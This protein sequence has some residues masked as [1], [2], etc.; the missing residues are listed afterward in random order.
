MFENKNIEITIIVLICIGAVALIAALIWTKIIKKNDWVN[1]NK[2]LFT[3]NLIKK[4][5]GKSFNDK[6]KY[7]LM[8]DIF[9]SDTETNKTCFFYLNNALI[10]T[11]NIFL[12]T[13]ELSQKGRGI[14]KVNNDLKVIDKKNKEF[15]F[16]IEIDSVFKNLKNIKKSLD[17]KE[18]KIIVP[19]SYKGFKHYCSPL[20]ESIHFICSNNLSQ[21]I[22]SIENE[23]EKIVNEDLNS[24]RKKI[25]SHNFQKRIK[26][27]FVNLPLKD[28]VWEKK[29]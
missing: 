4:D 27:P 10:T 12:I 1:C 13:Y 6:D 25:A 19:C 20:N 22:S 21:L 7:I 26:L 5:I 15:N 14:R 11:K 16:P 8:S 23:T 29:K 18:I 3:I 28:T 24:I 2:T 17:N 9:Y